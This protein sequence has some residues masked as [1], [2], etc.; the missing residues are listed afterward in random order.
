MG[1]RHI[2][3]VEAPLVVAFQPIVL[4]LDFLNVFFVV[5]GGMENRHDTAG[6]RLVVDV[7]QADGHPGLHGDLVEAAFPLVG[8]FAGAFGTD[9]QRDAVSFLDDV[10]GV[11]N[12]IAHVFPIHGDAS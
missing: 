1:V 8:A 4:F 11:A 7:A 2:F 3:Q 12:E 9:N 10:C 6:A 5:A